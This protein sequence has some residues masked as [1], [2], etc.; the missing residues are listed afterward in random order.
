MHRLN[1]FL[2]DTLVFKRCISIF[3]NSRG[4]T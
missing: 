4:R 1:L 3:W 2:G